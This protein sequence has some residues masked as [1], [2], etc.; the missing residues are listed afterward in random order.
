MKDEQH[1]YKCD[2][3]GA[4]V[5]MRDLGMVFQHEHIGKPPPNPADLKKITAKKAGDPVEWKDGKPTHL[6]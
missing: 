1:F 5:D 6:N 3:C 2:R 4:M